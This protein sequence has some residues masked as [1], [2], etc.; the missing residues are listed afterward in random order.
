[1]KV[2]S[3]MALLLLS[4]SCA[5]SKKSKNTSEAVVSNEVVTLADAD[6]V[7]LSR[8]GCYGT[9]PIFKIQVFGNGNVIYYG[10]QFVDKLGI[11]TGTLGSDDMK[12]LLEKVADAKL[13]EK[14][15]QYPID[16]F[17][18][19]QFIVEFQVGDKLKT[20]RGNSYADK[21]VLELTLLLDE[22]SGKINFTK[23]EE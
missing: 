14:P 13:F 23:T 4:F 1:M 20:I 10:R 16:N 5:N 21:E 2:L 18:F 8:T 3:V 11:Y 22:L 9:C 19:P 6:F 12:V 15:E 17:D 7:S